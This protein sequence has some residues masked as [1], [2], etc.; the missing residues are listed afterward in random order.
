MVILHILR[1]NLPITDWVSAANNAT[2]VTLNANATVEV[3]DEIRVIDGNFANFSGTVT[4]V[5]PDKQKLKINVS[6][7]GRPTPVELDFSQVE[8]RA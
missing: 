2:Y 1:N 8:K 6:I 3:G 7:F 5:R 4:E